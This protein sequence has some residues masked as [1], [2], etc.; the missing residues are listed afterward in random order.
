[1]TTELTWLSLFGII[2]GGFSL[3]LWMYWALV[4][5]LIRQQLV[6][7]AENNLDKLRLLGLNGEISTGSKL[8]S[9]IFSFLENSKN[10]TKQERWIFINSV[11]D[12]EVKDRSIRLRALLQ[13]MDEAHPDIRRLVGDTMHTLSS[14]YVAQRPFVVC[15]VAPLFALSL[16]IQR[17]KSA[18]SDKEVEFAVSS[19]VAV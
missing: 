4:F 18:L 9:Q 13:E 1:M 12:S 15:V 10:A 6:F 7:R 19:L 2:A 5:P 16:F 11:P 17:A 3:F 14:L 8:Y